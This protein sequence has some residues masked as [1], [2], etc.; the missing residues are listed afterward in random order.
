MFLD[1]DADGFERLELP[2]TTPADDWL[3]VQDGVS[4]DGRRLFVHSPRSN[5]VAVVDLAARRIEQV[6]SLPP[7]AAGAPALVARAWDLISQLFVGVAEAKSQFAGNLQL[8]PDGT[9]LY[10]AALAPDGGHVSGVRVI[11]TRTWA[12]LSA[13]LPEVEVGQILLSADGTRLFVQEQP[14]MTTR[15]AGVVH[16]LDASTGSELAT[17]RGLPQTRLTSV[18]ELYALFYGRSPAPVPEVDLAPTRALVGSASPARPA[19]P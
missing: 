12:T 3:E 18:H 9:R 17:S 19:D 6:A 5:T 14:W 8:A 7:T 2:L 11:D 10:A 15:S 1:T 4:Q 16:V 13:W